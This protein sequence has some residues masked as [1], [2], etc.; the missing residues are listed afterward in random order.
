MSTSILRTGDIEFLNASSQSL[1]KA[2]ATADILTFSSLNGDVELRGIKTPTQA[3]S[4]VNKQYVDALSAGIAWKESCVAATTASGTLST[5]FAN[6]ATI[7]GIVLTTNDRLLIKD[8]TNQQENGIYTVNASG[9]PTRAIDM[10]S[11]SSAKQSAVFVETGTDNADHG[12]V[13]SSGDIVGTDNLEWTMF[14][15]LG[16][17]EAGSGLEKVGSTLNVLTDGSTLEISSDQVRVKDAG[18]IEAKLAT[19][20]VSTAKIVNANVTEAKLATD[21][22]STAKIVNANVTTA[23]IADLNVTTGKLAD[24]AVTNVKITAGTIANDRLVNNSITVTAGDGLQTG[25]NVALGGSVTVDVDG[26][27]LRTDATN[28]S[29]SGILSLTNTTASSTTS[30]GALVISGGCGVAGDVRSAGSVYA[31]SHVSTSDR[32]LKS[33]IKPVMTATE[34]ILKVKP[35]FYNM[36]DKSTDGHRHCGVVAQELRG[37]MPEA[38][39]EDGKGYLAVDYTYLFTMLLKSHQEL[40]ERFEKNDHH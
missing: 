3:N 8:Q 20:S 16:Q 38:V 13:V 28:Q 23:K 29:K 36:V 12:F 40:V 5:S 26:T 24:G 22:V 19:D 37:V 30:T 14:T 11:G 18:I 21:S 17:V 31:V 25:G 27:V 32:R 33:D 10:A 34:Q 35:V 2:A 9:A 7:D 6:G 1:C 4:G 15:S 39:H